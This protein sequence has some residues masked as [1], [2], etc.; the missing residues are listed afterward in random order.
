M[1][2][3]IIVAVVLIALIVGGMYASKKQGHPTPLTVKVMTSEQAYEMA[4]NALKINDQHDFVIIETSEHE[5][6]WVFRYVPRKYRDTKDPIYLVPGNTPLVVT[7]DGKIESLADSSTETEVG[8][9][10][11]LKKWRLTYPAR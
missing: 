10:Q 5:F 9:A 3:Y 11:Y 8:I 7:R 6:G 2:K 4:E 1:T